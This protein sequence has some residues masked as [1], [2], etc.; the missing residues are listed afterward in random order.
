MDNIITE[1]VLNIIL[2]IAALFT[3]KIIIF[4]AVIIWLHFTMFVTERHEKQ[5][6]KLRAE[7]LKISLNV[8]FIITSNVLN[9]YTNY[10]F[11]L[12]LIGAD[13]KRVYHSELAQKHN[14]Q[15]IG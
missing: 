4:I 12:E 6:L 8:K 13:R 11:L 5:T 10:C 1:A 9:Q 3:R 7:L 14:Q 2:I 15:L